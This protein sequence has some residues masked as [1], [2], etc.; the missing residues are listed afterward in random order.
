MRVADKA[1]IGLA[2][3]H[4]ENPSRK[5]FKN[6]EVLSRARQEFGELPPGVQVHLSSHAVA[7]TT[8]SSG[9]YKMVTR[10]G[11]GRVRLFRKGDPAHPE[12]T[13]KSV[14]RLEELPEKYHPLVRWYEEE[15]NVVAKP[16]A[17]EKDG[18]PRRLLRFVGLI[19]AFDLDIMRKVIEED[20][21]RIEPDDDA[22]KDVA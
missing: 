17:Q 12:R 4:K 9:R 13:D 10:T 11:R 14:P 15:Y 5:D 21:E 19:T 6:E 20:C 16:E 18:D 2:L 22:G 1:W 3:L 7:T 8:P